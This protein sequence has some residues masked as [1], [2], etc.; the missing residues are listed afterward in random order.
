MIETLRGLG[1]WTTKVAE[2]YKAKEGELYT[3]MC[4]R[5]D[6][7]LGAMRTARREVDIWYRAVSEELRHPVG[8]A[9]SALTK[10]NQAELDRVNKVHAQKLKDIQNAFNLAQNESYSRNE[11]ELQLVVSNLVPWET[12]VGALRESFF[13][14]RAREEKGLKPLLDE[15]I[16]VVNK[17]IEEVLGTANPFKVGDRV[18]LRNYSKG[19]QV[20][21]YFVG[22]QEGDEAI[23]EEIAETSLKL[24]WARGSSD[25]LPKW[26]HYD[27]FRSA[28]AKQDGVKSL[29]PEEDTRVFRKDDRVVLAEGGVSIT[30]L[31]RCE[32]AIAGPGS[33]GTVLVST[34]PYVWVLW[35]KVAEPQKVHKSWL[36][37]AEKPKRACLRCAGLA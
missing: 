11:Q 18:A 8:T 36:W 29:R 16:R 34:E 19:M 31:W 28:P 30:A 12:A 10:A 1:L 13:G 22:M 9:E 15:A 4:R 32:E 35:D 3:Q 25:D 6:D 5:E 17:E 20:S 37:L 33:C 14:V 24:R 7:A 23:V 21:N 26:A 27:W 2:A